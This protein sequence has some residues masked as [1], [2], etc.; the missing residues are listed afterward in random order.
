MVIRKLA[1]KKWLY[2]KEGERKMGTNIEERKVER[3]MGS[4][5]ARKTHTLSQRNRAMM[6]V[7]KV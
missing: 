3:K 7:P 5:E 2:G 1:P 4:N 6:E